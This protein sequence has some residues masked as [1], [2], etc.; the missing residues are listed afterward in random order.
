MLFSQNFRESAILLVLTASLSGFLVP[1]ILKKVD[2]RKLKEQKIID[3]RKL[4]EQKEFEAELARQNKV[5]EAQAQLLDNLVQLL[6][7]FHLLVLAVSYHRVNRDQEKYEAAVEEYAENAWDYFGKIR[8]E[9]SK[10][11]R[12]TSNE[13]YQ[14]LLNFYT[15]SLMKLDVRLATLIRKEA[16]HEEWKTH[17]DLVFQTLASQVDQ[18]VSL[19]AE[20]LRL[21]SRTKLSNMPLKSSM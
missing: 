20:E 14:T 3:D 12:L 6:W 21:S 18:I 2:E 19:L 9:I 1:Y 11:A 4:R 13:T 8:T 10:A 5:I 7:E 17:H 15:E 16:P